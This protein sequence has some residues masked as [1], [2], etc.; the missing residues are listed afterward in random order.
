MSQSISIISADRRKRLLAAN[1]KRQR[2]APEAP[3]FGNPR[4]VSLIGVLVDTY[5]NQRGKLECKFL[6]PDP[7]ACYK[8]TGDIQ[9]GGALIAEVDKAE[10]IM[11][12]RVFESDSYKKRVQEYKNAGWEVQNTFNSLIQISPMTV[13]G[14]V[15]FDTGN[16]EDVPV[17]SFVSLTVSC[18]AWIRECEGAPNPGEQP[19]VRSMCFMNGDSCRVLRDT[20]DRE[21]F[22]LFV[23]TPGLC[24]LKMPKYAELV[25]KE[26]FKPGGYQKNSN[27]LFVIPSIANPMSDEALA[28]L[29]ATPEGGGCSSSVKVNAAEDTPFSYLPN[30]DA[31]KD[32][33]LPALRFVIN[34]FSHQSEEHL[35]AGKT[36]LTQMSGG[37][38]DTTPF[39]VTD[40]KAWPRFAESLVDAVNMILMCHVNLE[41]ASASSVNRFPDA[42]E[43]N[44]QYPLKCLT[45]IVDMSSYVYNSGIPLSRNFVLECL[46]RQRYYKGTP[47]KR[48]KVLENP[49]LVN[50]S[51]MATETAVAFMESERADECVFR[52]MVPTILNKRQQQLVSD[53]IEKNETGKAPDG[54]ALEALLD[55]DWS[56][57]LT[58]S[59][60]NLLGEDVSIE[61]AGLGFEDD[62]LL[63]T[64]VPPP[65]VLT[66]RDTIG[67]GQVLFYIFAVNRL[68]MQKI[69]ES[70]E[71]TKKILAI[72]APNLAIEAPEANKESAEEVDDDEDDDAS[73]SERTRSKRARTKEPEAVF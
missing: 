6:L 42:Q 3:K 45:P 38:F 55:P 24:T 52:A 17:N 21:L 25:E 72:E 61:K 54:Q 29:M 31:S 65:P 43:A 12:L 30:K 10:K 69:D 51:E 32:E 37:I 15:T 28:F 27:E 40:Q 44:A 60:E 4:V 71:H 11:T 57:D 23:S 56:G 59:M 36:E 68:R 50:L 58:E 64:A 46:R 70:L 48:L 13:L 67:G 26:N 5:L 41:R 8:E 53:H 39:Y 66:M 22:N 49:I 34:Y 62:H 14:K 19:V 18:S 47:T 2:S 9:A 33:A 20:D 1:A 16:M 35:N 73:V 63:K 7:S